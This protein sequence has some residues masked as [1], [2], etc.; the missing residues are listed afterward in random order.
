[1]SKC[2]NII[3][4]VEGKTEIQFIEKVLCPYLANK[5]IFI[6]AIGIGGDV[7]FCRAKID[8]RNFLRQRSDL[9]VTTFVDYYGVKEWPEAKNIPAN[10]SPT[11]IASIINDATKKKF[12]AEYP[13]IGAENRFIPFIAVHELEALLFSDSS[14]LAKGINIPEEK[15]LKILEECKEP[16]AINNSSETAPSKRLDT[17]LLPHKFKKTTTGIAIAEA[18]GIPKMREKCP[19]FN[20]WISSLEKL[21][22]VCV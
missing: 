22:E 12:I 1:M 21:A 10:I 6:E 16:E 4:I 13:N 3:A 18:I 7:K 17:L 20:T 9:Y 11:Q 19:N 15:I 2:I 14:I 8:I 5:N